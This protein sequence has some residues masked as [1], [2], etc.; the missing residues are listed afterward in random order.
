MQI[1]GNIVYIGQSLHTQLTSVGERCVWRDCLEPE[2]LTH[3]S[4]SCAPCCLACMA[5]FSHQ[6]AGAASNA[7]HRGAS[8]IHTWFKHIHPLAMH[9][10]R[11]I[12]SRY[13]QRNA[14]EI[15]IYLINYW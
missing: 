5:L 1:S 3:D 9:A 12:G 15:C 14:L 11:Y 10:C 2:I 8:P 13:S 4:C 6:D 7:R